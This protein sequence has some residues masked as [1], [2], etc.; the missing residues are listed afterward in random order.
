MD[1]IL[2]EPR[3]TVVPAVPRVSVHKVMQDFSPSTVVVLCR[4]ISVERFG[5]RIEGLGS[6]VQSPSTKTLH[7]EP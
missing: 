1:R 5:F 4:D 2:H 6:R 7:L 3:S